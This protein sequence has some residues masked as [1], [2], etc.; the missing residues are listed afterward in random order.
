MRLYLDACA[1]IYAIEGLPA[2][3][4]AVVAHIAQVEATASGV[5]TTSRLSRLECRLKPLRDRQ[6][7]LL[8][9]Y[10]KFFARRAFELVEISAAV[11]ERATDLRASHGF[12]TPD[13]LHLAT[14]IEAQ[15]DIFLTGDSGLVRCPGLNVVLI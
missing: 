7:D 5:L 1:I 11:V 10:D 14:A 13:A 12:K 15:V 2:F 6:A 9:Q 3:R 8:T 4:G